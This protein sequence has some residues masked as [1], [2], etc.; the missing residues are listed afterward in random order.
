MTD[1]VK[2]IHLYMDERLTPEQAS[3]LRSRLLE[4]ADFARLFARHGLLN[5]CIRNEFLE[6]DFKESIERFVVPTSA[7]AGTNADLSDTAQ[8]ATESIMKPEK[9]DADKVHK[10]K[11]RAEQQ[12]DRKSVV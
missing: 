8:V 3:E 1:P 9:P 5:S 6:E 10:I 12:L 7:D 2:L 4:D 11:A